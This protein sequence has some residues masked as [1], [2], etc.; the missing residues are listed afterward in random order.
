MNIQIQIQKANHEDRRSLTGVHRGANSGNTN[1]AAIPGQTP[2]RAKLVQR[3]DDKLFFAG[4]A[5]AG[6]FAGTCGGAFLSGRSTAR[7][8]AASLG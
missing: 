7:G 2:A 6:G 1:A 3:L 4:E 8:V 5:C